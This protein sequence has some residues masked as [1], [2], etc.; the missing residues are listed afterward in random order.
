MGLR[1]KEN[2]W[3]GFV[4]VGLAPTTK[5]KVG[6]KGEAE[7]TMTFSPGVAESNIGPIGELIPTDPYHLSRGI[8]CPKQQ[9][10]GHLQ[11]STTLCLVHCNKNKKD[12]GI[13]ASEKK[14]CNP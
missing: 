1:K 14:I 13:R 11:P 12:M 8:S 4:A 6:S 9:S 7:E 3:N 5:N 2:E 10:R